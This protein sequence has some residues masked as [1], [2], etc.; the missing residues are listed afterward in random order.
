M[1]TFLL[2]VCAFIYFFYVVQVKTEAEIRVECTHMQEF[3]SL[4]DK[5]DRKHRI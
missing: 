4:F 1:Y 2:Y 3:I 5:N